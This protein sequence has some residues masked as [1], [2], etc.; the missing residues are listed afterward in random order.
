[1]W[2]GAPKHVSWKSWFYVCRSNGSPKYVSYIVCSLFLSFR[3]WG[4]LVFNFSISV[5]WYLASLFFLFFCTVLFCRLTD[6]HVLGKCT[7]YFFFWVRGDWRSVLLRMHRDFSSNAVE[8]A[9]RTTVASS[10]SLLSTS[11]FD[12]VYFALLRSACV[13][14]V[15]TH[16]IM[17]CRHRRR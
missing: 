12:L 14:W 15:Q 5:S 13:C 8:V 1:M 3:P 10:R 2:I 7:C 4:C 17:K 16:A 6:V 9:G 11:Q